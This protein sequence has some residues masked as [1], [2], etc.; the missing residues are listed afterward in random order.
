MMYKNFD[1]SNL[2]VGDVTKNRAGGNQVSLLYNAQKGPI[3]LQTPVM[4]V[5][6]GLSEF[7]PDGSDPKYSIDLSFKGHEEN[8][9]TEVFMKTIMAIDERMISL[10]VSNSI[11]WFGKTM[12]REVVEELYRPLVKPSKQPEKYAPTL[13]CKI[14]TLS[15]LDAFTKERQP[16]DITTLQSG[17]TVK[18]ILDFS[19]IWFVNKQFGITLNILQLEMNSAPAGRLNGFAFIEDEDY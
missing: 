3:M 8:T 1:A 19:P 4:S 2:I 6:F 15:K 13:K 9:R 18:L 11:K 12:S 14:R 17:S 7:I 16:F 5:P 10:G